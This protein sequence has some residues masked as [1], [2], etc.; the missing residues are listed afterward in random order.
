VF[1]II[2]SEPAG[3]YATDDARALRDVLLEG[4]DR[5]FQKGIEASTGQILVVLFL[6]GLLTELGW[7]G[8]TGAAT[9]PKG[10]NVRDLVDARLRPMAQRLRLPRRDQELCRQVFQT[11]HRMVPARHIRANIRRAIL[12]RECLSDALWI[13]DVLSRQFGGDFEHASLYW[14][15]AAADS[16]RDETGGRERGKRAGTRTPPARRSGRRSAE[17]RPQA[18]GPKPGGAK[19]TPDVPRKDMPPV[20]DERYFFAALPTVP[21]G[22]ERPEPPET[23]EAIS[24]REPARGGKENGAGADAGSAQAPSRRRRRRRRRRK[25][26]SSEGSA[27]RSEAGDS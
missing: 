17:G 27:S 11:L 7:D 15:R 19:R 6:P 25:P 4:I 26:S 9:R 22:H 10:L 21:S 12:N 13:L 23:S 24:P 5:R 18:E 14:S 2:L 3:S 20:W 8:A 1:E 16:A